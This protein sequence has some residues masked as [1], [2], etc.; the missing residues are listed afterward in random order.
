MRDI[1][2]IA[3]TVPH[4]R[5]MFGLPSCTQ[6]DI[7]LCTALSTIKVDETTI[8]FCSKDEQCPTKETNHE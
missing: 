8:R 3:I 7:M 5:K 2:D 6:T 4:I 1:P